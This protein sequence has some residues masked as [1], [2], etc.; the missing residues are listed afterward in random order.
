MSKS[1]PI[2][3]LPTNV[4]MQG[5]H[6]PM[7]ISKQAAALQSFAIPQNTSDVPPEDDAAIQEVLNQLNVNA[8]SS[9]AQTQL[10]PG[11]ISSDQIQQ[12]IA[13]ESALAQQQHAMAQQQMMQQQMMQQQITPG[14]FQDNPYTQLSN[15]QMEMNVY[16]GKG[17]SMLDLALIRYDVKNVVIVVVVFMISSVLPIE[18]IVNNYIA[19]DKI[20]YSNIAIKSVLAGVLFFLLN[21]LV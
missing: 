4:G 5:S 8:G 7:D 2:N 16:D 14:M 10:N 21:K 15:N 6:N 12:Q 13:M 20:P 1:T 18:R 17:N 11:N 19:I 9:S 3:Q